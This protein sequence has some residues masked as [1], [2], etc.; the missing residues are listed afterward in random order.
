MI[1]EH[2]KDCSMT[3]EEE[4]VLYG[5]MLLTY[6]L[7]VCNCAA[8]RFKLRILSGNERSEAALGNV[9]EDALRLYRIIVQGRVTPCTLYDVLSDLSAV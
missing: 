6:Q 3:L 4:T 8:E 9:V 5:G 2:C 1:R 7:L